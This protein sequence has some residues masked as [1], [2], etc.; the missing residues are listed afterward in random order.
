MNWTFES[1]ETGRVVCK[2]IDAGGASVAGMITPTWLTLPDGRRIGAVIRDAADRPF[3]ESHK[4]N[5]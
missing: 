3:C 2:V 1:P 5:F 4:L